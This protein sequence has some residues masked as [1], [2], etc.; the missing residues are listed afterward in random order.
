MALFTGAHLINFDS[1]EELL[2]DS[3]VILNEIQLD[4]ERFCALTPDPIPS[5]LRT[6]FVSRPVIS[7]N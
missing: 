4:F 5:D 2:F 7:E 1:S 3:S 6:R